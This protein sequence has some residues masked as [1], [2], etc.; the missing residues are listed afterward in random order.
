MLKDKGDLVDLSRPGE[1]DPFWDTISW[2]SVLRKGF[3]FKSDV[4]PFVLD[5]DLDC[6]TFE[7]EGFTFPWPDY[8][9][10]KIYF[11]EFENRSVESS[12]GKYFLHQLISH[13]GIVT[14][15]T[16][17]GCCGG[18]KNSEKILKDLNKLLFDG[19]M[20]FAD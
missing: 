17:P 7:L 16:E 6:F 8:A 5:F 13:A 19:K 15:S 4:A 14:I 10:E 1:L 2:E 18:E 9:Y 20:K 3:S 11:K 12:S